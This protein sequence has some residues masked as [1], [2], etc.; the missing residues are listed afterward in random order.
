MTDPCLMLLLDEVRGKTV[1]LLEA[2]SR[3]R[4]GVGPAWTS[5]HDSLARRPCL[6]LSSSGSRA[7]RW[8]NAFGSPTAGM[9]CLAGTANPAKSR[10]TAGRSWPR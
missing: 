3:R 6:F 7:K 1:R 10:P 2:V 8:A 4:R 9:R 5:K